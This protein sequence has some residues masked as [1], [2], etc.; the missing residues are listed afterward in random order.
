MAPWILGPIK[1]LQ[2][3]TLGSLTHDPANQTIRCRGRRCLKGHSYYGY[4]PRCMLGIFSRRVD[5]LFYRVA[6]SFTITITRK[7]CESSAG[8]IWLRAFLSLSKSRLLH[9]YWAMIFYFNSH[10]RRLNRPLPTTSHLLFEAKGLKRGLR[11]DWDAGAQLNLKAM[12]YLSLP[13]YA[14]GLYG[15]THKWSVMLRSQWPRL[16]PANLDLVRVLRSS[17][18]DHDAFVKMTIRSGLWARRTL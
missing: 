13:D 2:Y 16:R 8:K 11:L 4:R 3:P 14:A 5:I 1:A 10:E 18:V 6:A 9:K 17:I 15:S 12:E 7:V